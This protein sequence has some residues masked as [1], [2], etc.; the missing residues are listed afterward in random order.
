MTY[1]FKARLSSEW[2]LEKPSGTVLALSEVLRLLAAIDATGHIA[3]ACKAC[4]LSYRPGWGLLRNADKDF[5]A[6][7]IEK[8]RRQRTNLTNFGQPL[9]WANRLLAARLLPTLYTMASELPY[10]SALLHP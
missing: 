2:V 10:A 6:P 5:D 8:S 9:L 4:S 3:G 7:P 1:K